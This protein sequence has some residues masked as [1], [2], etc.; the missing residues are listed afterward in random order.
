MI[1]ILSDVEIYGNL[2]IN[3]NITVK[4]T[5]E[6]DSNTILNGVL[7]VK[8]NVIMDGG[9][10]VKSDVTITENLKTNWLTTD[11]IYILSLTGENACII[12]GSNG[13]DLINKDIKNVDTLN[14]KT[15]HTIENYKLRIDPHIISLPWTSTISSEDNFITLVSTDASFGSSEDKLKVNRKEIVYNLSHS[16]PFYEYETPSGSNYYHINY[17]TFLGKMLVYIQLY[18]DSALS[19]FISF[20]WMPGTDF[21]YVKTV[22]TGFV[23]N[24]NI[25]QAEDTIYTKV[26]IEDKNSHPFYKIRIYDSIKY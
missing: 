6:V 1:P 21:F 23:S 14:V 16:T 10:T 13:I 19:K 11:G 3:K 8:S 20:Y 25:R 22:E 7:N 17:D 24:V 15:I 5:L 9:L 2:N 12:T 26:L 4:G 18:Y